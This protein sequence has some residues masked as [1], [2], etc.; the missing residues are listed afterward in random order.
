MPHNQACA[1]LVV[2]LVCT[3]EWGAMRHV[4]NTVCLSLEHM[5]MCA[6]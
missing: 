5:H 6:R 1:R 2:G 3:T 4:I